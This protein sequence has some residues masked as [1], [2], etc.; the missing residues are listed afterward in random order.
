MGFLGFLLYIFALTIPFAVLALLSCTANYYTAAKKHSKSY[1]ENDDSKWQLSI[2]NPFWGKHGVTF[3]I[4]VVSVAICLTILFWK[5]GNIII[6]CCNNYGS[7][8]ILRNYI[9]GETINETLPKY[10]PAFFIILIMGMVALCI[11]C[12]KEYFEGKK[13]KQLIDNA[14]KYG[15]LTKEYVGENLVLHACKVVK[16][17]LEIHLYNPDFPTISSERNSFYYGEVGILSNHNGYSMS[18]D[19]LVREITKGRFIINDPQSK[20]VQQLKSS[21]KKID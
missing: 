17:T 1:W 15:V 18:E 7:D 5:L 3:S 9:I 8:T 4:V 19:R 21:A 10:Y 12:C 13:K 20:Y 16:N 6:D 11:Y 14:F 2:N